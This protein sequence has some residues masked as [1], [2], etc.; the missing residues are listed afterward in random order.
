M[1]DAVKFPSP[2]SLVARGASSWS[3]FRRWPL[4]AQVTLGLV[5][6][7]FVGSGVAS[8]RSDHSATTSPPAEPV[9]TTT[10]H[11]SST[12]TTLPLSPE[13]ASRAGSGTDVARGATSGDAVDRSTATDTLLATLESIR[14]QPEDP[15]TNYE[16]ALFPHWDDVDHDGCDTRC[17]V[18]TAQRRADG[19]WLSEWD[20]Y[21]TSDPSEL[22]I[23]H[24]VALA[25]AWDSG[26]DHWTAEQRDDFADDQINLLAV[27]AAANERKSDSDA[28]EWFPSRAEANCLWSSTVV[29]VKAKWSLTVDQA[30]HDALA[31]LLRTCADYV[32]PT[33]TTAPPSPPPSPPAIQPTPSQECTPGYDPC[34][35]PGPD[36]DCAGGSGN[37]PRYVEGPIAVTGSDPYGLDG[38]GDGVGCT[39]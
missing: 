7:V 9:T 35:P 29:R 19:T 22:Q 16:R 2:S 32:A 12:T 33:T 8:A 34:I 27:T 37:G 1:S 23:D 17:E 4:W 13:G 28:A 3:R 18:L 20:G 38:N 5:V 14:V 39:S 24:V 25:E 10:E 30:E 11:H 21:T 36:V 26:A 15:R 6:V 31:N